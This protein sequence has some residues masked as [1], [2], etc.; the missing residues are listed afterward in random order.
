MTERLYYDNAKLMTFDAHIVEVRPTERG[1]IVR[2][3]RTAF[4]PT[5][6]GQPHDT[7]SL[8]GIPVVDVWEDDAHEVWHLLAR[9][10][11]SEITLPHPVHGVVDEARRFDHMQQHSGQH[12][13]SAAFDHLYK[14][15]TLSFHLGS[16]LSTIDVDM[17]RLPAEQIRAVE[18]EV[19]RVI[20]Q[21][22]PVHARFVT[23]EELATIPL[24]KPPK[25]KEHIRVVSM[26][27]YEHIACGGTHVSRTGE[28]GLVKITR[29]ERYKGHVRVH[30]LCGGRALR[31]YRR[32]LTLL[33]ETSNILSVGHEETPQA[34]QRLQE[35]LKET[36][37]ALNKAKATLLQA[38][39]EELWR[40]TPEVE[41]VRRILRH[42]ERPFAEVLN[43]ARALREK[44]R[45]L[46]C[47]AATEAKGLR[48]VCA[49]S[50]D[51]PD[52]HAGQLL[53]T[54]VRSLGG[55]GGGSPALAQGGAP[56]TSA[57]TVLRAMEEAVRG[58]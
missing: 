9:P 37:A 29:A 48:L 49:R 55:R 38:E 12:L 11:P 15:R 21:D 18:E 31:H 41:G 23:H 20:W 14:A 4:Y 44:P 43:L 47:L 1:P 28:I 36:R 10:L 24:R 32:T 39:A 45:T 33:Q 2:L 52:I 35:E 5:S 13:L 16:E 40:T 51:L 17:P 53:R 34:V 25:V 54:L 30:F 57:E 7:G 19:N 6:G 42:W 50:D 56:A 58:L 8:D 22:L 26:G 46:T 27:D 3:D